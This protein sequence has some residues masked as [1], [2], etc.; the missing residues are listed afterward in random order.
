MTSVAA[1]ASARSG[2][3]TTTGAY[4]KSRGVPPEVAERLIVLGFF[5]E[6]V[7]RVPVPEHG[8]E[9]Y[10]ARLRPEFERGR[11]TR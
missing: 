9:D 5:N 8:R 10:G 11:V 2:R 4:I 3:S 6:I 7:K 1:H